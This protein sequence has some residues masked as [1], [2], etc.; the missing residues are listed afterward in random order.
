MAIGS[1]LRATKRNP[2]VRT[3]TG[4]FGTSDFHSHLRLAAPLRFV[5]S[6]PERP[7]DILELGCGGGFV[8][9]EICSRVEV[10]TALGIDL[11][12]THVES[13]NA[14]RAAV[15]PDK[16]LRF[17]VGDASEMASGSHY[18]IILL[19]DVLEHIDDVKPVL[20]FVRTHL[21][22]DGVLLVSVPTPLYPHVFG[23]K[24]HEQ[25]GHVRDGYML[26]SLKE[27]CSDFV[28]ESYKYSTG[29]LAIPFCAFY[30]RVATRLPR[31]LCS[32]IG[33]VMTPFSVLDIWHPPALS[34]S[35]F[36]VLRP[37]TK[38]VAA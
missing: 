22:S 28:V 36:A 2:V 38:S 33:F 34:C 5:R 27:A 32:L 17:E 7:V 10:N 11:S 29:P 25:I 18:D 9:T 20:D 35:L 14:L 16:A 30:Y 37:A 21:K 12:E 24:F 15:L 6:L 31:K 1:V 8:L 3:I 23:R 26:Q 13:A 4:I 19:M